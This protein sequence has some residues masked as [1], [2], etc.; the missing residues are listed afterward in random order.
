MHAFSMGCC[1]DAVR[2][3]TSFADGGRGPAQPCAAAHVI[4]AH[5][6]RAQH[7]VEAS[8][9]EHSHLGTGT[10]AGIAQQHAVFDQ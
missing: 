4:A 7:P 10:D 9:L 8:G 5:L 1:P 6:V 3:L 2:G